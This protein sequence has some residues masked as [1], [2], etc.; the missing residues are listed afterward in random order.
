[1]WEEEARN[2][3]EETR[4]AVLPL[5]K[6]TLIYRQRMADDEVQQEPFSNSFA[7]SISEDD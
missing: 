2:M 5:G 1:M 3:G 7:P 4:G 6:G